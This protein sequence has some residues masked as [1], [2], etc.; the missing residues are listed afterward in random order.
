MGGGERLLSHFKVGRKAKFEWEW[1]TVVGVAGVVATSPSYLRYNRIRCIFLVGEVLR[2][3]AVAVCFR[4]RRLSC[5]TH[6][7]PLPGTCAICSSAHPWQGWRED[8]YPQGFHRS[9]AC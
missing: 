7:S 9:G 8:A 2:G 5:F 6:I 1:L 3:R 4:P